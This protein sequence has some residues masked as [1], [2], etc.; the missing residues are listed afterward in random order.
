MMSIRCFIFF[1]TIVS[2]NVLNSSAQIY[3]LDFTDTTS[4]SVDCGKLVPSYWGVKL[5]SCTLRTTPF[6]L[7][8]SCDAYDT[9]PVQIRINTTGNMECDDIAYFR[10]WCDSSW[11]LLDTIHGCGLNAVETYS[12]NVNCSNNMDFA[13]EVS[14]TNDHNTEFYQLRDDDIQIFD[15]C[16]I[17][18]GKNILFNA[19]ETANGHLLTLD[20]YNFNKGI[21]QINLLRSAEGRDFINIHSF[22]PNEHLFF[23][24]VEYL[25]PMPLPGLNYYLVEIMFEDGRKVRSQIE[26]LSNELQSFSIFPYPNPTFSSLVVDYYSLADEQVAYEVRSLTGKLLSGNTMTIGTEG[27]HSINIAIESLPKGVYQLILF[28][29]RHTASSLIMK[30]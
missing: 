9:I 15:P 30:N 11:N 8:D 16:P 2:G 1:I 19:K 17:L 21:L 5:D 12:Y 6:T 4:F 27:I 7:P 10:Y 29:P 26:V 28:S 14:F 24:L 13:I 3:S 22:Y 18:L 25:D 23:G 20:L